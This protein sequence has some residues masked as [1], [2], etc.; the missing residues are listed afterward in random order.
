MYIFFNFI[1]YKIVVFPAQSNLSN[2]RRIFF[3]PLS[4]AKEFASKGK[5]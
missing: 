5:G 2:R 3:D 1:A 4:N